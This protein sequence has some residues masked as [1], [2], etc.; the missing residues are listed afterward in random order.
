MNWI[1]LSAAAGGLALFLLA[2]LMMTEGLKTYGGRSLKRL[3]GRWTSTP[4]RGVATGTLVT[5]LVQSSS[6]VG[7]STIGFVNAGLMSLRQ[8][9]A[10]VFG[11]NLGTAMTG[12]LVSLVG[13][14]FRIETD[15]LPII[16]IGVAIHLGSST[17][18]RRG[19]GAALAGLVLFLLGLSVLK[20]ALARLGGMIGP[21]ALALGESECSCRP[22]STRSPGRR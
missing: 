14:D 6:A 2:M 4:L 5:A 1:T 3:L 11:A 13:F 18:R 19:L 20:D 16:A 17:P 10:V 15:A 21:D 7:V 8:A 12:W 9:L 22:R